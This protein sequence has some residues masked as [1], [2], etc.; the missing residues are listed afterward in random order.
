MDTSLRAHQRP[1]QGFDRTSVDHARSASRPLALNPW[2]AS[3]LLQKAIRWGDAALAERAAMTLQRLRGKGTWRR[4]LVIAFEGVS[5]APVNGIIAT[6]VACMEPN[7]R[8]SAGG[9]E[10]AACLV[11]RL[12]AKAPKDRLPDN[13][14]CTAH[15]PT[16]RSRRIGGFGAPRDRDRH[17]A[18]RVPALL[19]V[20]C[21]NLDH[22]NAIPAAVSRAS[23]R[24]ATDALHRADPF[25][26]A[27]RSRRRQ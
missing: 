26:P 16:G 12:L 5:G 19:T 17:G 6:T 18:C 3:T 13:L 2:V 27:F 4:F 11:A 24:P 14:I 25:Q 7:G 15:R 9:N 10:Q 8:E 21:D 20:V 1:A 23:A 22:L